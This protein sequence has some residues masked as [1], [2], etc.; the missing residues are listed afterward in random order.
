MSP[1]GFLHGVDFAAMAGLNGDGG[2]CRAAQELIDAY[3]HEWM[4]YDKWINN[5][6]KIGPVT[7]S[8]ASV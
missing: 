1:E 7:N 6:V 8:S 2:F 4:P 3:S 5:A